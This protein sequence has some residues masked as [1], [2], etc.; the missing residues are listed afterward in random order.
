MIALSWVV[1]HK[2]V[3]E[4]RLENQWPRKDDRGSLPRS[5][6]RD[7]ELAVDQSKI[8]RGVTPGDAVPIVI[9]VECPGPDGTKLLRSRE[10]ATIAV[11]VAP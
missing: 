7:C 3:H 10:D 8:P 9:E 5:A 11:R 1:G 2:G 4:R 6:S